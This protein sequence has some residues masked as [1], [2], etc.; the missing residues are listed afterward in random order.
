M[1]V[2]R[3]LFLADSHL[4]F[5][6]PSRPRI[7]RRRRGDDFWANY[8]RALQSA[9]EGDADAVV[10]GGD[11]FFRA[12]VSGHVVDAAFDLLKKIGDQGIPVY[13]VPGNHERS[14]I[15]CNLLALHPQIHIFDRPRTFNLIRNGLRLAL[16]G[17]PYWR[18]G[19]RRDFRDVL[20]ATRWRD[21]WGTCDAAV[22]CVHHCFEGATVGPGSFTFRKA[23]DVIRLR[24]VPHEFCAVL[25][26]HIHRHQVLGRDLAGRPLPTP[27]LYAGSI[28]RTSWAEA[29]EKKGYLRVMIKKDRTRESCE[30]G[31]RFFE[32]PARPMI[33]LRLPIGG[34]DRRAL[35][36]LLQH[37]L[38][39]LDPH[40]VVKIQIEGMVNTECLP[41][42]RAASLRALSPPGM[43]ISLRFAAEKRGLG[44]SKP[45]KTP[46]RGRERSPG[47]SGQGR[48][49]GREG[50]ALI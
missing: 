27:V 19:I 18:A 17:F 22:L 37:S 33:R 41:L 25:S 34:H 26:G 1:A 47:S 9:L 29:D 21:A 32:L 39:R 45:K 4:G 40:S 43:N 7:L 49:A 20:D 36:E 10:H 46:G 14:R 48:R 35:R 31:W 28:E 44:S 23:P 38:G 5:D 2:I 15:P 42:L 16:A 30:V 50:K 8:R 11:L 3:L 13:V 24:E 6:L 12:R